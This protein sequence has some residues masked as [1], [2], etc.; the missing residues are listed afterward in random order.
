MSGD[1]KKNEP[2]ARSEFKK[3]DYKKVEY[4]KPSYADAKYAPSKF[5]AAEYTSGATM[6]ET[7]IGKINIK[8]ATVAVIGLGYV[9]LPLAVEFAEAGYRVVGIDVKEEVVDRINRGKSHV[10]DVPSE[11]LAPLVE[12]GLVRASAHYTAVKGADCISVCVPT[13]LTKTK[14]PDISYITDAVDQLLPLLS[15]G[16]LV[17][18]ES[19]TYPGT[20]E[21]LLAARIERELKLKVG[22]QVFV[23]FSPERVDPGN[24]KW[25]TKNTPKVLGGVTPACTEVAR[26]LY[27]AALDH[28]HPVGS[29]RE[30][31][32]V[33]LLENTFRA[34]NIGLVNE[35]MLMCDRLEIDVWNVI[36]AAATKPFG[37]MPFYPG[38]GIGGHCIPLDPLY[39][40]WKAKAVDFYNRF[41]ELATD[42]NGNMP[43][44]VIAKLADLLNEQEKPLKG[45]RVMILGMAY[46]S[47]VDDLRESPGLEIYRLLRQKGAWVEFNDPLAERFVS[48]LGN[49][50]ESSP[51]DEGQLETYDAAILIT[52]HEAFD[53]AKI[54]SESK[55]I[56]DCRNAFC[57]HGIRSEKITKL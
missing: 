12:T 31:E 19:T 37:Y 7:L 50:V 24:E 27:A 23:A 40:S 38:P 54:A 1:E 48:I 5:S 35:F 16:K 15:P 21:E 32:T 36:E 47:N 44:F 41:I 10:G 17:V 6:K 13:P 4:E 2:Y 25:N 51:I 22:E 8:D 14:D 53:Y 33:K 56:L 42:I 28:V 29:A 45:S 30:A 3:A 20:T 34:V 9:G 43:R 55:L 18:L 11:R 52:D 57:R 26:A 39:M 46:K 49:V